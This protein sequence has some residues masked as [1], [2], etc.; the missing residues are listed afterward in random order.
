MSVIE[1]LLS[2]IQEAGWRAAILLY[3]A[4]AQARQDIP[5]RHDRGE[6]D[7]AFYAERVAPV[8]AEPT[9][10]IADPRSLIAVAVPDRPVRIRFTLPQGTLATRIPPTYLHGE[11]NDRMVEERVREILKPSGFTA[12]IASGPEKAMLTRCG[13]GRYGR[14]NVTYVEGMGSYHRPVVLV[15]DL[16]YEGTGAQ[17]E[18]AAL[19]RCSTCRACLAVCPTGGIGEDRFLLYAERCLTFWNEKP[20]QVPFPDWI[21]P[22]WHNALV[23][24]FRCREA[25]PE[26]RGFIGSVVEGPTFDL[27]ASQAILRGVPLEN[28]PPRAQKAL[29]SWDLVD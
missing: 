4:Q 3:S 5:Q 24:C 6:F 14:N 26:K 22:E 28:L 10:E 23:G 2:E 7:E 29:H 18:P 27:V 8:V 25:C 13:L 15:S 20:P 19:P 11:R 9:R 17:R 21:A 12:A 1:R 16:P